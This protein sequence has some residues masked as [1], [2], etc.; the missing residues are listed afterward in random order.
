MSIALI[1]ISVVQVYWISWSMKL[2][3]KNFDDKIF[4]VLN[5]VKSRLK[6]DYSREWQQKQD[7]KL[8]VINSLSDKIQ[9]EKI[10]KRIFSKYEND[11]RRGSILHQYAE[12]FVTQFPHS[13]LDNIDNKKLDRYIKEAL[14]DQGVTTFFDYA[15]YSK[16]NDSFVIFNGN[17]SVE[18]KNEGK[19]SS[20]GQNDGLF[21]SDYRINLYDDKT[22]SPGYL[23]LY[24]P[25]K[26]IVFSKIWFPL[27]VSLLL[28][29][30]LILGFAYNAY[31]ILRQKRISEMRTDFINN[32]THEFKTPIATISLASDALANDRVKNN[33]QKVTKFLGIIKQENLRMLQQVEKVLQISL[34]DKKEF[35]L[36]VTKVDI[37]ELLQQTVDHSL[38][39]V[40][41]KNGT[42][43][44]KFEATKFDIEGDANHISNVFHNLMDNA[45]KYTEVTP[46]FTISTTSNNKGIFII[47]QDNGIGMSKESL[48]HIYDKFYRVHTGNIHN[49]KGF[50]LGLSYVKKIVNEH[51]GKITVASELGKGT[52]FKIFFPFVLKKI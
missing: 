28:T 12:Q 10:R 25:N 16:K 49:V 38:L 24:F 36:N 13:F 48:K 52:K 5:N 23:I 2:E 17:Y 26:P 30:L 46:E 35:E 47:I 33:P 3:Q 18:I 8:D 27:I 34:L 50:G 21:N 29:T 45:N 41:K 1:G 9:L 37:H 11:N 4:Y 22:R 32:M 39:Q 43:N 20:V 40:N 44:T 7:I 42:I 31:T 14:G 51:N 6:A 19:S 15:I